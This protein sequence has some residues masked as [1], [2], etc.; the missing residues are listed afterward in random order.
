MDFYQE[1]HILLSFSVYAHKRDSCNKCKEIEHPSCDKSDG[2]DYYY[3]FYEDDVCSC[4]EHP[5]YDYE[6]LF[7]SIVRSDKLHPS[8]TIFRIQ[9]GSGVITDD[10]LSDATTIQSQFDL[11]SGFANFIDFTL[12]STMDEDYV[13]RDRVIENS[14]QIKIRQMKPLPV[15]KN[16][17]QA[18]P[19]S[20]WLA[21]VKL[22][23][24]MSV[25]EQSVEKKP[26]AHVS[27]V[28]KHK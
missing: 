23:N 1:N 10:Q 17:L 12:F 27:K 7:I 3:Y 11:V 14:L 8:E 28:K 6:G 15:K 2:F 4:P 24:Q 22:V 20:Y 16:I 26:C 5:T 19:E 21:F 13:Q 18:K 25:L 9:S